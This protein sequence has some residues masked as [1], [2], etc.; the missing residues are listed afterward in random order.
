MDCS[1]IKRG[2]ILKNW[3]SPSPST[4]TLPTRLVAADEQ[5]TKG[6]DCAPLEINV[7]SER[8]VGRATKDALHITVAKESEGGREGVA[9]GT[10]ADASS[11]AGAVRRFGRVDL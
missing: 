8:E 5:S 1:G 3:R 6:R 9:H 4:F 11:A 10:L 7:W 2:L